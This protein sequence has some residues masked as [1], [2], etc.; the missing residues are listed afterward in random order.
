MKRRA[1]ECMKFAIALLLLSASCVS[2]QTKTGESAWAEPDGFLG[3][4]FNA[5]R[6]LARTKIDL[7]CGAGDDVCTHTV[8]LMNLELEV[9]FTF[10]DDKLSRVWAD[11]AS[12]NF[13]IVCDIFSQRYGKPTGVTT[14]TVTSA[15]GGRIENETWAWTGEKVSIGI[16]R[17]FPR[18]GETKQEG[19]FMVFLNT[20]L[21]ENVKKAADKL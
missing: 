10:S 14:E 11:F 13:G 2:A 17:Y 12:A 20:Y 19:L 4:P 9:F 8:R 1:G 3:V 7:K 5:S 21:K 15:T 6:A 16:S 18:D